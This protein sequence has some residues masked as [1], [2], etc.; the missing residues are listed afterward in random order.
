MKW[1]YRSVKKN[2]Q[3]FFW[4]LRRQGYNILFYCS[5]SIELY[6]YNQYLAKDKMETKKIIF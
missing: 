2:L 3:R 6:K 5:L 4:N 1:I